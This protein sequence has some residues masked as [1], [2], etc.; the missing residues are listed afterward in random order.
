MKMNTWLWI[1]VILGLGLIV[2]RNRYKWGLMTD[3]DEFSG[4]GHGFRANKLRKPIS[5]YDPNQ[6]IQAKRPKSCSCQDKAGNWYESWICPCR[7][8]P[9]STDTAESVTPKRP[10]KTIVDKVFAEDGSLVEPRKIG[11]PSGGATQRFRCRCPGTTGCGNVSGN[12]MEW[13]PCKSGKPA[14]EIIDL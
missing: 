14:C 6:P 4:G 7:N 3:P 2:Y 9:Y 11:D 12:V 5:P 10:K 13:C 8:I 1:A